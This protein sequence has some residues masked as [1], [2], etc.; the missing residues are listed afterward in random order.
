MAHGVLYERTG[1]KQEGISGKP[2]KECERKEQRDQT[3]TRRRAIRKTLRFRPT[4]LKITAFTLKD[5]VYSLAVLRASR[6]AGS[7]RI[8]PLGSLPTPISPWTEYDQ[9]II[10]HLYDRGIV[11][12]DPNSNEKA[13]AFDD[14]RSAKILWQYGA[15]ANH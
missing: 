2:C 11:A 12:V 3:A 10:M 6:F 15:V 14:R 7:R 1:R 4:T 9:Q 8:S 13:F 5:T